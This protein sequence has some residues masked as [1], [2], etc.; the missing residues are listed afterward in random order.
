MLKIKKH[1]RTGF[2]LIELLVVILI[3]GILAA[4]VL[5][6]YKK[7]VL[8]TR[9]SEIVSTLHV[10]MDA[11]NR[12]YLV[13]NAYTKDRDDLDVNFPL[14]TSKNKYNIKASPTVSCGLEAAPTNIYCV[15]QNIGIHLY[16]YLSGYYSGYYACRNE[17]LDNI[18]NDE[19]CKKFLGT[20]NLYSESDTYRMYLGKKHNL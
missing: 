20:N 19:L 1:R 16:F 6:Q 17:K 3:I 8:K 7:V 10:L 4:V 2:T 18:N 11:E 13:H 14:S 15:N 12:Y 5:P 9:F